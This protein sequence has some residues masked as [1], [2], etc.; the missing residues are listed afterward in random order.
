MSSVCPRVEILQLLWALAP[1]LDP[2]LRILS[3]YVQSAFPL[4]QFLLIAVFSFICTSEKN[5][6]HVSLRYPIREAYGGVILPFSPKPFLLC[7]QQ[8]HLSA[9][10]MSCAP[11]PKSFWWLSIA[12]APVGQCLSCTRKPQTGCAP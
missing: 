4:V 9:S 10:P 11:D 5:M 1:V 12:H 7:A 6:A 3:P 2:A 8:T